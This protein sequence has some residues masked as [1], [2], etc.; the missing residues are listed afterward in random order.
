MLVSI[1][2]L[3]RLMLNIVSESEPLTA[4]QDE[5]IYRRVFPDRKEKV[6]NGQSGDIGSCG[7]CAEG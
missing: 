6:A 1:D 4:E 2:D 5:R 7:T 3:I